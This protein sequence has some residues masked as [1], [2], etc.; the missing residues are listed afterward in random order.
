MPE[1]VLYLMSAFPEAIRRSAK[2]RIE[3]VQYF[4]GTVLQLKRFYLGFE[5]SLGI[6]IAYDNHIIYG[7]KYLKIFYQFQRYVCQY[8]NSTLGRLKIYAGYKV[9]SLT[10]RLTYQS[11]K[12]LRLHKTYITTSFM[13]PG[14]LKTY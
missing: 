4:N 12:L 7:V 14:K 8:K 11:L 3:V 10:L 9:V 13:K 6:T 2:Q 5:N 1:L